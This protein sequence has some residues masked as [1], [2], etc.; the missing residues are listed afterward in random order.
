MLSF[1]E[2]SLVYLR[3]VPNVQRCQDDLEISA[4]KQVRFAKRFML[5]TRKPL[6]LLQPS[7]LHLSEVIVS[8]TM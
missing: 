2:L 8:F 1:T 4:R 6:H 7:L 3:V 5:C